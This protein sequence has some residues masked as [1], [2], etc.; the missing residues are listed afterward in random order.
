M[1]RGLLSSE[2]LIVAN[3]PED[4]KECINKKLQNNDQTIINFLPIKE[5]GSKYCIN[6]NKQNNELQQSSATSFPPIKEEIKTELTPSTHD[7]PSQVNDVSI[8][9][10]YSNI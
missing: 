6:E 4:S 9:C 10:H 7:S 2:I 1:E 8:P 5:E 3:P